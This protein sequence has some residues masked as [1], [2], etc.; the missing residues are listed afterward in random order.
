MRF[1]SETLCVDSRT[2][3]RVDFSRLV[4]H[5]LFARFKRTYFAPKCACFT[6]REPPC[7]IDID[8]YDNG[9]Y[10]VRVKNT[11]PCAHTRA[12]ASELAQRVEAI[13][14]SESRM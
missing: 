1:V 7:S 6:V 3:R 9:T 11:M 4:S 12:L 8:V 13:V 10:S 5:S 2:Q 14:V